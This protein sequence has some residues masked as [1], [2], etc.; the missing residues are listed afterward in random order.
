MPDEVV[1]VLIVGSGAAGA[2]LAWSLSDT[3]MKIVCLEQGDW[4]DPAKYPTT[5]MD[6]QLRGFGDMGLSPNGR[7]RSEDYPINDSE[8]PIH[9]SNFNA[10]GGSTILYAAHFPRF[11]PADFKVRTLDGVADDWPIDYETLAPYYDVNA[12]MMGVAGLSGD[13]ANPHHDFPLP[14]VPLGKVGET[15]AKG[16]NKLGWHWWPSDSAILSQE[17][18]GREPCINLGPCTSGCAQGAKASTDITYWPVAQRK[19]VQLRTGCRVREITVREDGMA[20]GVLYYDKEG[21]LQEQKAEIVVLACNGIGTPRLL[22]NSKSKLF[23][24]GLANRSGRVGRILMF[25]PYAL[26]TCIF[27]EPLVALLAPN[28]C[29]FMSQAFYETDRSR[30]FVRGYSFEMLRG[31]GPVSTAIW[32]MSSGRLPWGAD[33]HRAYDDIWDRTAG[34]VII[35]ED[36][37]DP[38]NRVTLD[39]ELVDADGIPAPKIHYRLSDNSRKMLD[40][41][42]ARGEEVLCAAGAKQTRSEAPLPPAGWHL[43]GTARMGN[44]PGSSVVDAHGRCH[45]VKN[46]F[47][48]DGSVFVTAGGVNPTNTLQA[49]ALYVADYMKKNLETL[50]E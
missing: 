12:R 34:M 28:G 35:C 22:L 46:L 48:V 5:A 3:R 6:W 25:P 2:A 37:P 23:H 42:V 13:P 33:H 26:V 45:D 16:F 38:E 24:D 15:L 1:D 27:N 30:G 39:P 31:M 7:G 49:I 10:V 8:S 17:Y 36:L 40:H 41:A 9:G 47:I 4:M 44:D 11:H 32:G 21:Q 14:P 20:D 19:G 43:M 50:F 18:E 29:C